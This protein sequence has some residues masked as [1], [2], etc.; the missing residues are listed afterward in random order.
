MKKIP[1]ASE[2]ASPSPKS[3]STPTAKP[4][5]ASVV[6]HREN[7][8]LQEISLES[9]NRFTSKY[10]RIMAEE[11]SRIDHSRR[12]K[13]SE[14]EKQLH[15]PP[16]VI[17][18][19]RNQQFILD[20]LKEQNFS[21]AEFD[22][23]YVLADFEKEQLQKKLADLGFPTSEIEKSMQHGSSLETCINWLCM[24]LTDEQLP[25]SFRA[26]GKQMEVKVSPSTPSF[27]LDKL[28]S[29]AG[30]EGYDSKDSFES[31]LI[32]MLRS[33]MPTFKEQDDSSVMDDVA[34][35]LDALK[36]IYNVEEDNPLIQVMEKE[37]VLCVRYSLP[38]G[39]LVFCFSVR[40]GYPKQPPTALLC[41][42][43]LSPEVRRAFTRLVFSDFETNYS[44]ILYEIMSDIDALIEKAKQS[45]QEAQL[46]KPV[47]EKAPIYSK[48]QRRATTSKPRF[49]HRSRVIDKSTLFGQPSSSVLKQRAS[50]PIVQY[51]QK[52]LEML[53]HH[54]VSIVSGGTGCGKSTQVPQFLIEEFREN[55][56]KDLNIV[57]CEPRR[58]SCLGLYNRVIEEQGFVAGD[59]CPI[60][61]QVRGDAK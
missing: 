50:L 45:V 40:L 4:V 3:P 5:S 51:K 6:D 55:D 39:S 27:S 59:R 20:L 10:D 49:S 15:R 53:R 26:S 31:T 60:G 35:E 37:N 14:L 46:L 42:P 52:V 34:V 58:I 12:A 24:N 36:C 18:S 30:F 21:L 28:P 1:V 8:E 48:P 54:Q 2:E 56:E 22:Q 43:S 41:V 19:E 25:K 9:K 7:K 11:K 33:I 17:L 57:V 13:Q 16:R 47:K 44:G 38:T 23:H 61:Y 32:D 29:L